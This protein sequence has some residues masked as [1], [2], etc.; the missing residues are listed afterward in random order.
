MTPDSSAPLLPTNGRRDWTP[1]E[2]AV[3]RAFHSKPTEAELGVL[4]ERLGRGSH[5]ILQ[6]WYEVTREARGAHRRAPA[7][8]PPGH[9]AED[10]LLAIMETQDKLNTK[11]DSI[12]HELG[13]LRGSVENLQAAVLFLADALQGKPENPVERLRRGG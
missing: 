3:L 13:A 7:G 10:A 8:L 12:L 2:E 4:A 11:L 1:S 6:K 5:A 9:D